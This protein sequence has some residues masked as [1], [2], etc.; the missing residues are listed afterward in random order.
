MSSPAY[1]ARLVAPARSRWHAHRRPAGRTLDLTIRHL[2][3]ML[4]LAIFVV[5]A[6]VRLAGLFNFPALADD[7]GTY[8]AQAFAVR[9]GQLAHY[10]YWYDHPPLGW[11]QLSALDWL[12][13]LLFGGSHPV[14][15]SRVVMVAVA[16]LTGMLLYPLARRMGAGRTAS[17]VAGLLMAFSPLAVVLQRQVYLDG[18]A[19]LWLVGA[20]VLALDP[21]QRLWSYVGAGLCF[22]VAVLSKETTAVLLPVLVWATMRYSAPRTRAFCLVGVVGAFALTMFFYPLMALLRG[23]VLPGTGRVSLTEGVLFQLLNRQGSGA[24]WEPG[25]ASNQ[26]LHDWMFYDRWLLLGG[27]VALPVT[28]A[29]RRLRP[30]GLMLLVI[31]LI[32]ARPGGYL[33]T[34]YVIGALPFL[35]LAAA[36]GAE[37]VLR[38]ARGLRTRPLRFVATAL[39]AVL[40]TAGA[41]FVVPDW[42]AGIRTAAT[43]RSND[44]RLQAE[45]WMAGHVPPDA[46]VLTDDVSWLGLVESGTTRRENAIWFYKL[47][48]DPEIKPQLPGGWRDIDYVLST[49]QL[50]AAVSANPALVGS[51]TALTRS[52]PVATFGSGDSAVQVRAVQVRRVQT[53]PLRS[54]P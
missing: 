42:A 19:M 46:V 4:M 15:A 30:A 27:L 37:A 34:M 41:A 9:D 25:S 1:P 17:T 47:D 20:L 36:V 49:D 40:A 16:A 31:A 12:P 24:I 13:Q 44:A 14:A 29:V 35:A 5:I 33:P 21:R 53:S 7:E 38:G 43:T 18:I 6:G 32:G 3:A 10:T 48:T 45:R 54:T 2:D 28:L 39:C 22:A 8:A 11:I 26:V 51:A 52:V 23:E 50:R